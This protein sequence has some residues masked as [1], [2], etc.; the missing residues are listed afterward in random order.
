MFFRIG[1]FTI[2]GGY[3]MLPLIEEDITRRKKW[4]TKEEMVDVIAIIQSIPGVIAINTGIFV[5]YKKRGF[6]GA[7]MAALGAVL[8]SLIV[9]IIIYLALF[10]IR[11]NIYVQK[12]FVGVRSGVAALITLAVFKFGKAVIKNKISLLLAL[13]SFV[14]IV[15]FNIHISHVILFGGVVGLLLSK[16]GSIL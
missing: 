9:I 3:A 12:A 1:L 2:G 11:D 15:I 6:P 14:C 5:G 13:F 7:I 8:P 4:L 16:K 10:N